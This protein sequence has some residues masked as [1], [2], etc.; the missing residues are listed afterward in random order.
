[1]KNLALAACVGPVADAPQAIATPPKP[2]APSRPH[3]TACPPTLAAAVAEA[4]PATTPMPKP[5]ARQTLRDWDPD[6]QPRE[7]LMRLGAATL[8]TSELLA[9]LLRT[10]TRDTTACDIGRELMAGHEGSL[11]RLAQTPWAD[12]AEVRGIGSVKAVT[13]A[14]A[15]E[16]GRRREL[17]RDGERPV[18][19]GSRGAYELLAPRLRDL[20]HEEC[21][22]LLL[23]NAGRLIRAERLSQGGID[24][25]VVDVRAV[26]A[27]AIRYRATRIV[28]GHNHPSGSTTPSEA[29]VTLTERLRAAG[30]LLDI[31]L[32]DH[33]I[34]AG[35]RYFSFR[36][37]KRLG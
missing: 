26:M 37:A 4:R 22:V 33:V 20:P 35:Q 25:T 34:V 24:G 19:T 5:S 13:L 18:V 29:D 8:A 23:N 12:L 7:R 15:L 14:A 27:V 3:V 6:E 2:A 36:D 28:L 10:G 21:W 1:M 17:E 32:A 31:R 16:L 9:I 11:R 30:E